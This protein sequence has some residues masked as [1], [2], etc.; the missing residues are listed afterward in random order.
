VNSTKTIVISHIQYVLH[1]EHVLDHFL[2]TLAEL[3]K[4]ARYLRHVYPSARI[5]ATLT[6]RIYV[7]ILYWELL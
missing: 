3:Q 1:T 6:G 7:K 2:G 4:R 5:S